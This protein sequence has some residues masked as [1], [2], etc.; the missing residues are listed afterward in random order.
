MPHPLRAR[1][2]ARSVAVAVSMLAVL[3]LATPWAAHANPQPLP[4]SYIYETLPAGGAE[5]EFYTDL[6]PT[7]VTNV[8]TGPT[9]YLAQQ[10]QMEIEYG[11]TDRLELGL[12]LTLAPVDPSL[13]LAPVMNEGTGIKQRLRYRFADAGY[14]PVDIALYG[15]VTENEREVEPEGKLIIQRRLGPVRAVL[16]AWAEREFYYN[17]QR[18]WELNPTAGVVFERWISVQP[19]LEYWMHAEYADAGAA[20]GWTIKPEQYLGPTVIVQLGKIWWTTGAYVR[21]ND[22]FQTPSAQTSNPYG[23]FW[24]RTIIGIGF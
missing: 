22:A 23:P 17:G 9:W 6:A 10:Y 18:E 2:G 16:N 20:H 15:E 4:Y 21:L 12:Y 11:L 5:V 1:A 7:R 3:V 24:I 19:G 13:A 14:L 8:T